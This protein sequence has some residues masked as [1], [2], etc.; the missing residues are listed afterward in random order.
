MDLSKVSIH[1]LDLNRWESVKIKSLKSFKRNGMLDK[2]I[3]FKE[4]YDP[5]TDT[6]FL[7]NEEAGIYISMYIAPHKVSIMK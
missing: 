6:L 5:R 1:I 4:G 7:K 2:P 3:L